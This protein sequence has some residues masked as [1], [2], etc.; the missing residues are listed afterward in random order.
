[1]VKAIQCGSSHLNKVAVIRDRDL[2]ARRIDSQAVQ[3]RG[4]HNVVHRLSGRGDFMYCQGSLSA[5]GDQAARIIAVAPDA[6]NTGHAGAIAL[7][8]VGKGLHGI[9]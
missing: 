5:A 2:C 3:G 8:N 6:A 4:K 9:Y 7:Y 1:M